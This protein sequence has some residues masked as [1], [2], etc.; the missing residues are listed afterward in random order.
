MSPE[1]WIGHNGKFYKFSNPSM[2]WYWAR[3]ECREADPEADLL[4]IDSHDEQH[5]INCKH[6]SLI[7]TIQHRLIDDS[8]IH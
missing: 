5:F 8:L 4:V 3:R 2:P 1:S 6:A 7:D